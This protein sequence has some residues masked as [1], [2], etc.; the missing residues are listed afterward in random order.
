VT[1]E[2]E[3]IDPI[4]IPLRLL[5]P[6]KLNK[7][8]G[9]TGL[10]LPLRKNLPPTLLI[11]WDGSQYA[12]Y[13]GGAQ[14]M[15]YFPIKPDI[16]MRGLL[17]ENAEVVVDVTSRY[18]AVQQNDPR[19]AIVLRDGKS[20]IVGIGLGDTC[21]DPVLVPLWGEYDTGTQDEA[22]G[23]TRWTMI[24]LDGDTTIALWEQDSGAAK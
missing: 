2:G 19:G 4:A 8:S 15:G 13:L 1:E 11:N 9:A 16:S 5:K 18:D 22:I 6:I 17:I 7:T 14:P 24:A 3:K 23:F 20:Y 12:L 21:A 10:L